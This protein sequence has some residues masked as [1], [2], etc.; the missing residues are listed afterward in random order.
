MFHHEIVSIEYT[1]ND[2]IE[3]QMYLKFLWYQSEQMQPLIF[4][5]KQ[6]I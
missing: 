4:I 5:E 6:K 2:L 1:N 3:F